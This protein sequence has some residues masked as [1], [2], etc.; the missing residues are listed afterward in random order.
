MT[1]ATEATLNITSRNRRSVSK[2]VTRT[3]ISIV[4]LLFI[5]VFFLSNGIIFFF[6]SKGI[7]FLF[8]NNPQFER[9]STYASNEI[10]HKRN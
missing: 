3:E 4:T 9:F 7:I 8:L 5:L 10:F 6:L 1:A 2:Y